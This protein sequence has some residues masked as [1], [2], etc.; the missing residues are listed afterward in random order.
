MCLLRVPDTYDEKKIAKN[1]RPL[2]IMAGNSAN[3]PSF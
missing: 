3:E 1:L 2:D